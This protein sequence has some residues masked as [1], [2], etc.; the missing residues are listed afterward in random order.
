MD[1]PSI[2]IIYKKEDYKWAQKFADKHKLPRVKIKTRLPPPNHK[3][4][5]K[6]SKFVKGL[7]ICN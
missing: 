4:A 5:E 1:Y 3:L 7:H 2:I 6:I